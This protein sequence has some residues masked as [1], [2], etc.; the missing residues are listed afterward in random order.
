MRTGPVHVTAAGVAA[1]LVWFLV[2]SAAVVHQHEEATV[3]G[4]PSWPAIV[5]AVVVSSLCV[6]GF[7]AWGRRWGLGVG[8]ALGACLLLGLVEGPVPAGE[9]GLLLSVPTTFSVGLGSVTTWLAFAVT[10]TLTL[11]AHPGRSDAPAERGEPQG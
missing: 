3:H 1:G 8:A 4:R 11:T 9:A 2:L 10:A 7:R 6:L 5:A